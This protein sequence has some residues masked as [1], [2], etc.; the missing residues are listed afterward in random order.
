VSLE[1][2]HKLGRQLDVAAL[3][4]LDIPGRF[5]G[6]GV[7]SGLEVDVGE[8]CVL[9]LLLAGAAGQQESEEQFFFRNACREERAITGC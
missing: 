9:R 1:I 7:D 2:V 5:L 3:E 6:D 4:I 8:P